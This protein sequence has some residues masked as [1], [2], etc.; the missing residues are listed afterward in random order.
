MASNR[1]SNI[2]EVLKRLMKYFLEGLVVSIVAFWIP[3][4]AIDMEEILAIAI[5]AA[6]TFAVLDI[7][8]TKTVSD[9]ARW[10]TGFGIGASLGANVVGPIFPAEEGFYGGGAPQAP[11]FVSNPDDAVGE[12][13]T[14]SRYQVPPSLKVEIGSGSNKLRCTWRPNEKLIVDGKPEAY[15]GK[16]VS[17]KGLIH[18]LNKFGTTS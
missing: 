17:D 8:T 2:K 12:S 18:I 4:R 3:R 11:D 9:A 6:C 14:E 13:S 5:T 16:C 15:I 7:W 10:G 1:I